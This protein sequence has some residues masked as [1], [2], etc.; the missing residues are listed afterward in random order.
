[1]AN[2]EL[3][4]PPIFDA[5]LR[6]YKTEDE[7]HAD[8]FNAV[9]NQLINNDSY[10][11]SHIDTAEQNIKE[12]KETTDIH[13]TKAQKDSWTAKA[14]TTEATT[15]TK[16][17]MSSADKIKLSGIATGAE[18]NQNAFSNV[19][20]GSN[21]VS[22]NGK[23]A[24]IEFTSGTNITIAADNATKKVT[25]NGPS[26]VTT[27]T[28][29]LMTK[30]DKI[31]LNNIA[32]NANNYAHP[33][34]LSKSNGLYKVTIDETGHVSATSAV[35]KAD[36][37]NLGIPAQDTNTTYG[38][39]TTGALGL[40]KSG[41]DITV[42]SSGNVSVVDDSHNHIISNVDGLQSALDAKAASSHTHSNYVNQN[43]FSNVTVGS[44]TIAAGSATDTLT[45]VAGSNVNLVADTTNDKVTISATDT[46]YTHPSYTSK[47]N[48]LYK[49]TIDGTGHVSAATTVTKTD[50]TNLGIPAQDTKYT[51]PTTSGY[52]H[53]PSGGSD[54]QVLKWSADG[55]AIWGSQ[56]KEFK[57]LANISIYAYQWTRHN[58][59]Y[60]I[61]HTTVK[62]LLESDDV[63]VCVD[64]TDPT[65]SSS[66]FQT[67][68]EQK[69]AFS[70]LDYTK[71]LNN[72]L[73][74]VCFST[75]PNKTLPLK[76]FVLR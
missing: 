4:I 49:V 17:L 6:K 60:Y 69:E 16:G 46:K 68:K 12:H 31:K 75:I 21:V 2:H 54:G 18:V 48:N 14:T 37:T 38:V 73:V 7:V 45:L 56:Q 15:T 29:G 26:N 62:G 65:L 50:I 74:C 30:E 57:F 40:V 24:T 32:T 59:G 11:K 41:T 61:K 55:T 36:I 33:T 58:D 28:N 13:V 51:H 44:T 67:A 34:Y 52:R 43:A 63:F 1:M 22:A 19:K 9:E 3:S 10:L 27:S 5:N 35:T 42:D 71:A 25:I 39:A 47:L 20:V 66:D 72:E 76:I 23:T 8:V 70:H 53:I 64:S